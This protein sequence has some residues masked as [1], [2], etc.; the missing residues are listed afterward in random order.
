MSSFSLFGQTVILARLDVHAGT[1]YKFQAVAGD[2]LLAGSSPV[3]SFTTG[4]GVS[5][6][7]VSL[8]EVAS[9]VFELV[10]GI[11]PYLHLAEGA[12]AQPMLPLVDL[13]GVT[14]LESAIFGGTGYCLDIGAVEAPAT[15]M[16]AQVGYELTGID[17]TGVLVRAYP[18]VAGETPEGEMT[19]D[20]VLEA[21]GPAP[22][23]NVSVG[24]LASGLSYSIVLDAVGDDRGTLAVESVTVP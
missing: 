19:L 15:C 23:G 5:K 1:A 3:G 6:F 7:E 14:C 24:C 13:G 18:M 21:T 8:S 22:A 11:S 9:P 12:F 16:R 2:G 4:D 17:A 10:T 20:G